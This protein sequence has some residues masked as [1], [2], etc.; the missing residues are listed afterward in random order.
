M[1]RARHCWRTR[2][3][4]AAALQRRSYTRGKGARPP[5]SV[6]SVSECVT[7]A[8]DTG[9]AG[10]SEPQRCERERTVSGARSRIRT[11][12]KGPESPAHDQG[13]GRQARARA[14]WALNSPLSIGHGLNPRL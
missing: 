10:A 8:G 9:R 2:V 6:I 3:R 4:R 7:V 11:V 14:C 12:W 13:Y 5:A 1:V